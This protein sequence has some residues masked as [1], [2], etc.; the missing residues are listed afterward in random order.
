MNN[1]LKSSIRFFDDKD[2]G[3]IHDASLRLLRETGIVFHDDRAVELFKARGC[4]VSGQTVYIEKELVN[5]AVA[6]IKRT[7]TLESRNAK[8]NVIIGKDQAVQP[9]AGAVFIQDMDKGRR[10]ATIEDYGNIMKLAQSSDVVNLVGAHPINPSNVPDEFKH[11]YMGYEILKNTDKPVL[12]WCMTEKTSGEYLDMLQIAMGD[13]PGVVN[14]KQYSNVSVNPLSPLAWSQHTCETMME[15]SRR[16]QG[17]YLLPCIMAGLTGPM[18]PMGTI[19]LQNAEVLSGIVLSYLINPDTPVVYTPSSS[20]GYMRKGTY[21]TGTPE[22]MLLNS[23]LLEMSHEFYNMP[24]RCMCGMTDS[25]VPDA[26]AGLETM[27][28]IMMGVFSGADILVECVGVLD[29]IMTTSYEKHIMDEEIIK[30]ALRIREGFDT[31]DDAMSIDVIQEVGI[32]GNYLA[33]LD[34]FEHC[35]D[36][37]QNDVSECESYAEWTDTGSEDMLQRANK[38]Y[39]QRLADAPETMLTPEQDKDLKNYMNKVMG[40]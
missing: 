13:T 10:M 7:Y 22:M 1:G 16:G 17:L 25:K 31:S 2:F 9:N 11:L 15:Y 40:I 14:G 26:Q 30:R 29:A 18:R 24:T 12:G 35:H 21:I 4:R 28:N 6:N 23:P 37:F 38:I 32:G 19:L 27:Q 20:V 36:V 33:N 39:K 3:R 8:K 34:T 5:E